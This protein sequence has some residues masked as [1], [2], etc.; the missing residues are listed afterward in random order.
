MFGTMVRSLSV[1]ALFALFIALGAPAIAQQAAEGTLTSPYREQQ[2]SKIRG[3]SEKE[4]REL[5]DGLG[6]GLARAAELNGY[7]GPRHL[8]D[9]VEAGQMHLTPDQLHAVERLFDGMSAEAKRLGGT[10]LKEEQALEA[11]FRQ[12]SITGTDLQ[13]RVAQIGQLQAEL[14][15]VHLQTHLEAK[16]LL[17]AHQVERYNQLRGYGQSGGSPGDHHQ[18]RH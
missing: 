9:A 16:K 2:T 6:M 4:I 3:L 11:A 7:P 13:R 5:R 8:L 18:G 14:R 1:A 10:I 17:T 15:L 12:G